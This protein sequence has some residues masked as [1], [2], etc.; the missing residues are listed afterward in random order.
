MGLFVG[1]G[2]FVFD[3]LLELEVPYQFQ[4][5]VSFFFVGK[6]DC[7]CVFCVDVADDK[8]SFQEV[9]FG[10]HDFEAPEIGQW[11]PEMAAHCI[12]VGWVKGQ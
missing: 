11:Y 12:C 3:H 9:E 7:D 6:G 2:K 10:V 5:I 8:G 1:V 4:I